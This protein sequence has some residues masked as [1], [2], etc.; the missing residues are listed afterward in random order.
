MEITPETMLQQLRDIAEKKM[1]NNGG[2][3]YVYER[4]E[5]IETR[6]DCL[7]VHHDQDGQASTG[8]IIGTWAHESQGVELAAFADVEGIGAMSALSDLKVE[9]FN[10]GHSVS[11]VELIA[12]RV[13]SAQDEGTPWLQA[14]ERVQAAYES[15]ALAP[16]ATRGA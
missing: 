7:Y 16:G 2:V 3:D 10:P 9:G 5:H 13:Q 4:P 1:A 15:G 6:S 12:S 8:C 11:T 14:V